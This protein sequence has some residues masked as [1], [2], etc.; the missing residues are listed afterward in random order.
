MQIKQA[1]NDYE[2]KYES[3]INSIN[4]VSGLKNIKDLL[5]MFTKNLPTTGFKM[6][7]P[8]LTMSDSCV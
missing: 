8:L 1:I 6:F 3:K 7:N 4:V 2:T 5:P